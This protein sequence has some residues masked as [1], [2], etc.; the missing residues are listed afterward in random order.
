[1]EDVVAA[2]HDIT[3]GGAD[4]ALETTG[5]AQV[6]R[7][8][9]DSTRIMGTCAVIGPAPV[10][11][12]AVFDVNL[13]LI[14][15]TLRGVMG[16]DTGPAATL[17]TLLAL[18]RRGLFPFDRLARIYPLEDINRA[19]EDTANGTVFKPIIRLA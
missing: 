9:A 13:L 7:A 2:V 15:R 14:G 19:V 16:G 10:G 18:H 12:E 11:T 4:Y 17:P 3:D 8:A 5:N 1:V 6:L